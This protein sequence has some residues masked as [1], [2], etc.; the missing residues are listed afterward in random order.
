MAIFT[1]RKVFVISSFFKGFFAEN[2]LKK[3]V[4]MIS[5]LKKGK[6]EILA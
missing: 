2:L 6:K 3:M 4:G 1:S 5:W